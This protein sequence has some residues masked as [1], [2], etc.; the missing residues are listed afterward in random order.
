MIHETILNDKAA[1]CF[2]KQSK[3]WVQNGPFIYYFKIS[4]DIKK[5]T[6]FFR[7]MK[8]SLID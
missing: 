5:D 7:L 8:F 4:N 3:V 2:V 1:D 6:I